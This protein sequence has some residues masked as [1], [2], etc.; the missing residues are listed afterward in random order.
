MTVQADPMLV[1]DEN[2]DELSKLEAECEII[3][4]AF[5]D[6]AGYVGVSEWYI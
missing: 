2:C 1:K 3:I 6:V 5:Y 4:V